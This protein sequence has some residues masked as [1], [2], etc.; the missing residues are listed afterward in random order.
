LQTVVDVQSLPV[1]T[2]TLPGPQQPASHAGDV[3]QHDVPLP[4]QPQVWSRQV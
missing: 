1:P 3:L 4:P 2:H